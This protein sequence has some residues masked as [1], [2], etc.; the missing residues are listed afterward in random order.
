MPANERQTYK[1]EIERA[2][3]NLDKALRHIAPLEQLYRPDHADIAD[4]LA[5]I[6]AALIAAQEALANVQTAI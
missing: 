1:R 6:G 2:V 3:G 4:T 5:A